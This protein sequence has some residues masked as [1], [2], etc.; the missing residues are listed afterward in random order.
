MRTWISLSTP[1]VEEMAAR[2][3]AA[4]A[5]VADSPSS[6]LRIST[7]NTTA[8]APSSTPM[9]SV[10]MPSHTGAL[11]TVATVTATRANTR[12]IMAPRSS[13]STTGSSGVLDRRMKEVQVAEPRTRFDSTM[14]V[15]N[16]NPSSTMPRDSTEMAQ[17]GESISWGWRIF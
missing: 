6:R 3:A 15:L 8:M 13:S 14:A 9:D 1:S 7:I 16:E 4:S 10:P 2:M 11:K 12:P 5:L 17:S